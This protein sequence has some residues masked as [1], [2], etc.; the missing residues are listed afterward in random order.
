M[1]PGQRPSKSMRWS[2]TANPVSSAARRAASSSARS[3][4]AELGTS[5]T[6]PH[7]EHT[8]W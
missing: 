8:R 6:V 7:L 5:A 1:V 4:P 2:V 3:S